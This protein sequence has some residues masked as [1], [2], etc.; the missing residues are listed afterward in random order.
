MIA[1]EHHPQSDL[2]KEY[3]VDHIE[4]LAGENTFQNPIRVMENILVPMEIQFENEIKKTTATDAVPN[5]GCKNI[6]LNLSLLPTG[7]VCSCCG[8]TM[9]KIPELILG[10][11]DTLIA[12]QTKEDLENFLFSNLIHLWLA[13]DGPSALGK[14]VESET[15]SQIITDDMKHRCHQCL[16]LFSHK[17]T[18][19][20]LK[21][22]ASQ[23]KNRIMLA[24]FQ[25][26]YFFSE[27][28]K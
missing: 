26:Q 1:V 25:Q 14:I 27:M 21:A 15:G 6:A 16:A 8:L 10:S 2:N 7:E 13:V 24:F 4:E 5:Q 20:I 22:H 19:T 3:I 18:R 28:M 17:D 9:H 11:M 23:E 12:S